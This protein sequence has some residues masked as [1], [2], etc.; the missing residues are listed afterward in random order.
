MTVGIA[1]MSGSRPRGARV[2]TQLFSPTKR[3]SILRRRWRVCD[4]RPAVIY[5]GRRS[6]EKGL[7]MLP[8]IVSAMHRHAVEHRL[9]LVGDGPMRRELQELCRMQSSPARSRRSKWPRRR[10]TSVRTSPGWCARPETRTHLVASRHNCCEIRSAGL[11]WG[12]PR[13]VP[14]R[15]RWEASLRLC[16][17]AFALHR[18]YT[19]PPLIAACRCLHRILWPVSW[20][21]GRRR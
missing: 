18:R 6:R 2:Y 14:H 13:A 3:S 5:V 17:T 7:S 20:R 16:L 10:N 15:P 4:R 9:V 12:R 21:D 19:R 11:P 1:G 8:A